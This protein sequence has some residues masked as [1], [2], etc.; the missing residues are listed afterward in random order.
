MAIFLK[1]LSHIAPVSPTF[2]PTIPLMSFID[3][4][5]I[6][7]KTRSTLLQLKLHSLLSRWLATLP[8]VAGK[9]P[10]KCNVKNPYYYLNVYVWGVVENIGRICKGHSLHP[11]TQQSDM[12]TTR[13]IWHIIN[14]K[15]WLWRCFMLAYRDFVIF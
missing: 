15:L 9:S 11:L 8:N 5:T 6:S 13:L 12:L 10:Q 7:S 1:N 14:W 3:G 2:A 4:V